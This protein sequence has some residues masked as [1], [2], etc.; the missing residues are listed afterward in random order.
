ML[1]EILLGMEDK[2]PYLKHIEVGINVIRPERSYDVVLVTKFESAE[3]LGKYGK[4]P[5]HLETL[6][7][8]T[9]AVE[10]SAVVD[11]INWPQSILQNIT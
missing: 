1:R 5:A 8:I 11:Y 6:E 3:D 2:I 10:S 9:G 7:Y 4:H